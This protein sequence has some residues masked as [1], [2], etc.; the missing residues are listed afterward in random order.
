MSDIETVDRG[1]VELID[2]MGG[3]MAVLRKA[4]QTV[5]KQSS[6]MPDWGPK[7]LGRM[8]RLK[9]GTPFEAAVFDFQVECKIGVARE[10]FRHRIGSFNEFSM[11][12]TKAKPRFQVPPRNAARTETA[13]YTF[14]DMTDEDSIEKGLSEFLYAYDSAWASYT[15]LL[16]L[17]WAKELA[18][19]VLPFGI[20]TTFG[21]TVNARSL[22]NFISLRT[23]PGA[24]LEIREMALDVEQAFKAKMPYTWEAFV[25][26]GRGA[27]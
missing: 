23:A 11:R 19:D 27:P 1:T 3:D 6:E 25:A 22:M 7:F 17:G 2:F 8:V 18:R 24:M 15:R 9:H 12:V 14:E 16:K 21:W 10:W 13:R 20:M 26:A 5:G 4:R